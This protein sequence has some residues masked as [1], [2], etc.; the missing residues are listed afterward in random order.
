MIKRFKR[1][2]VRKLPGYPYKHKLANWL[3]IRVFTLEDIVEKYTVTL[4]DNKTGETYY[5]TKR[6]DT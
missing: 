1:Y 4:V 3:F 6:G 2:L 5:T